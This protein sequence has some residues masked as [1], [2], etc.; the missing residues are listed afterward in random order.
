MKLLLIGAAALA[1]S[2][3]STIQGDPTNNLPQAVLDNLKHCKRT[4]Q[5]SVGGLGIPG[6]S[7]YIECAPE[8]RDDAP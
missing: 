8:P 5:A 7:L 4:Y 3:C 2:G 1:L 6:G